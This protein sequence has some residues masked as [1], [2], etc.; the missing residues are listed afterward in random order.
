MTK[1]AACFTGHRESKLPYSITSK[2]YG[3]IENKLKDEIT[4]LIRL[5]VTE[6]YV[7]G[8]T[9]IDTTCAQLVIHLRDE[10]YTTLN[11]HLVI[12]YKGMDISF[13]QRQKDDYEWVMKNADSI[14]FLHDKYTP[15]C[16]RERNQYMVDRSDYLIAVWD[17]SK[18]SGTAMAMN[19]G[20][21]KGI[22]IIIISV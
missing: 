19:M 18:R 22:N 10:L 7:G 3:E 20:R 11:L 1:S 17:R 8:Q 16:F 15:S 14:T 4:N 21:R 13:N 9:G 2:E 6:Y 12:P 5:G